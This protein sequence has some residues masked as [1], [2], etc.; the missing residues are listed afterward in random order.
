MPEEDGD[1]GT[2]D[3]RTIPEDLPGTEEEEIQFRPRNGISRPEPQTAAP[4]SGLDTALSIIMD[5]LDSVDRR[6]SELFERTTSNR[7]DR[8][9]RRETYH[10][11]GDEY[12]R[13]RETYPDSSRGGENYRRETL[14]TDGGTIVSSNKPKMEKP[15]TFNGEYT[16]LYSVLNWLRSVRAYLEPHNIPKNQ[17]PR[18][19]YT[20]M[21]KSVKAW[22]D[23]LLEDTD[24]LTWSEFCTAIK[25]RYLPTDHVLQITKR[26]E[27]VTQTGT[28]VDY[29]EKWQN[30][31][32]AVRAAK[33]NRSEEDHVIQ[34][35]TGLAR[36][37][38]RK[39]IL[40]RD[41]KT[42]A[43]CY[44][45]VTTIRHYT[46]LAHKYVRTGDHPRSREERNTLKMLQGA[47]KTEAFK[48]G[49]C[50]GCG[51]MGHFLVDCP[52]VKQHLNVLKRFEKTTNRVTG[53]AKRKRVSGKEFDSTTSKPR[54]SRNPST[55]RRKIW[56]TPKT[57]LVLN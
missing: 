37:E 27:N 3:R 21:G 23:G 10:P 55:S 5:R 1:E 7:D 50:I 15:E 38:D 41:P 22:Y 8:D 56:G 4:T 17:Y 35:V 54:K 18:Y 13:R 33:I 57:N 34:F 52:A 11:T 44:R 20:Y 31:M 2:E 30:L 29:V 14:F 45:H 51:K 19:A 53:D 12:D 40:D 49:A 16:G 42:L 47:A 43:E 6:V 9:R 28:L 36:L 39:A 26:Y 46:L 25:E 32:V 48:K 24:D